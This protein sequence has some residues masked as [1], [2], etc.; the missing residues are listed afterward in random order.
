[1]SSPVALTGL[2]LEY[3]TGDDEPT[4]AKVWAEF[5]IHIPDVSDICD[6]LTEIGNLRKGKRDKRVNLDELIEGV[7]E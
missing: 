1:M 4:E 5:S 6:L 7:D 2:M 3:G